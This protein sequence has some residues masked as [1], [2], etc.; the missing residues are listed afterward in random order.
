MGV[1]H[2]NPILEQD[3]AG[4]TQRRR[5]R[6]GFR[7]RFSQK[8]KSGGFLQSGYSRILLQSGKRQE[9][10]ETLGAWLRTTIHRLEEEQIAELALVER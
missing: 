2:D 5:R 9:A 6:T 7:S 10:E 1:I 4:T 8:E 3:K